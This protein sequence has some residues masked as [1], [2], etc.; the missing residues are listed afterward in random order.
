MAFTHV[1][2]RRSAALGLAAALLGYLPA[3]ALATLRRSAMLAVELPG[4]LRDPAPMREVLEPGTATAAGWLWYNAHLVPTSV[5]TT[6]VLA[7]R[8][9]LT[10]VN[11]L[12]AVGGVAFLLYLVPPVLLVAA[13]YAFV[14]SDGIGLSM[15]VSGG[16]SVAVGYTPLLVLGAFLITAPAAEHVAAGPAGIPSLFAALVYPVVFGALGGVLAKKRVQA[17]EAA[18]EEGDAGEGTTETT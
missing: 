10:N 18:D 12:N 16:A 13:G 11:F 7:G 6:D 5:P 9:T 14:R 2:L 15:A 4:D 3:F 17:I 1:P 8:A